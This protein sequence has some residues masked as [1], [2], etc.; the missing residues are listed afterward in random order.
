MGAARHRIQFPLNTCPVV[1]PFFLHNIVVAH[2]GVF[3]LDRVG[4]FLVQLFP[5]DDSRHGLHA[6][7]LA[8]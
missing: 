4:L 3:Q 7:D 1:D 8:L 6:G 2:V 5:E